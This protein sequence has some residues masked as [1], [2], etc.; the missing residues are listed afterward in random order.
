MAHITTTYKT[1]GTLVREPQGF[2]GTL[3][4]K[5]TQPYEARQGATE[6]VATDEAMMPSYLEVETSAEEKERQ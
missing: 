3:C 4:D 2:G 6:K 1:D 5:A